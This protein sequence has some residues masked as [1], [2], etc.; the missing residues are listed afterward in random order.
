MQSILTFDVGGTKIRIVRYTVPEFTIEID[1]T[2]P[3]EKPYNT[4]FEQMCRLTHQYVTDS[5]VAI[6]IGVPGLLEYP[7]GVIYNM[8]NIPGGEGRNIAKELEEY[9]HLPCIAENDANCFA[10]AERMFTH[11][12]S[13][14]LVGI[15]L[16][17]GIGGG[18][19]IHGDIFRGAHG[20]AAEIGHMLLKPEQPPFSTDDTRGE[21]E[22]FFSGSALKHRFPEGIKE[23]ENPEKYT[24]IFKEMAWFFTS[25]IHCLDPDIIVLGGSIAPYIL[26]YSEALQAELLRSTLPKTPLPTIV[27]PSIEDAATRGIAYLAYTKFISS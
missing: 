12:N 19:I 8:P 15:T 5:T 4:F 23:D 14:V 27:G 1:V 9:S 3:T 2:V 10:Y 20:A 21:V 16:G 17:T 18:I 25:L 11:K 7:S 22:Q 24:T 13:R 26:Q 6:G